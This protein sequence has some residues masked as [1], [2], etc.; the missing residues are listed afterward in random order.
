MGTFQTYNLVGLKKDQVESQETN[1]QT[2]R[3][4][5]W[6]TSCNPSCLGLHP[7]YQEDHSSRP[8]LAKSCKTTSQP[9]KS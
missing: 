4:E 6:H 7:I 5:Q 3:Q 9:I 8:A 2:N 1:K